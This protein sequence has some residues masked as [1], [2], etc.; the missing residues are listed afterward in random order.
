[1]NTNYLTIEITRVEKTKN[2]QD[3]INISYLTSQKAGKHTFPFL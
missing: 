1:M 2:K 3:R